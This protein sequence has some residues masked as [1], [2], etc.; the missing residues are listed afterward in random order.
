MNIRRPSGV[1]D[2]QYLDSLDFLVFLVSKILR[3]APS[4]QKLGG[5]TNSWRRANDF[6]RLFGVPGHPLGA[7]GPS[8]LAIFRIF[9]A[10][11]AKFPQ[12]KQPIST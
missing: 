12:K 9:F 3:E 5:P 4:P 2:P 1:L 11:S 10:I 7:S 6:F 8:H